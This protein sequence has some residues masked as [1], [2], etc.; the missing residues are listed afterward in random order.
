MDAPITPLGALLMPMDVTGTP[1]DVP[2]TSLDAPLDRP[3]SF[4]FP[5]SRMDL[6]NF[7]SNISLI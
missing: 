6:H 7:E 5:K 3:T 2:F 4:I 1:L